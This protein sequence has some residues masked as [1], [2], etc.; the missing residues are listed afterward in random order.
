VSEPIVVTTP[1]EVRA[2]SRT[3]R[4]AGRRVALVPTMGALHDGHRS[5]I[6]SAASLADTVVVSIFVN[7]IQFDRADDFEAYPRL[8]VE[9]LALCA[10]AGAAIVYLPD[11]EHVYP[12]DFDTHVEPGALASVLEGE[13]RPG[14]F[15]GVAT[16]VTKLFGAVEPDLAVFG[17]KDFQQLA[18]IRRMTADLD[19][20]I[21][22]VAAPTQREPDGLAMSSRNRRLDPTARRAAVAIPDGL[23]A[24]QAAIA[25]G[26]HR[27]EALTD[28][29]RDHLRQAEAIDYIAI[30]DPDT[31][32]PFADLLADDGSPRPA[33]ALVAAWFGGVRLIDNRRLNG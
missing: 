32:A 17:E 5:L 29:V 23:A 2:L 1:A 20:G 8:P 13:H 21:E 25:D 9:D 31:L 26:E 11:V 3:E 19:L 18:V 30:V 33:V 7:P 10:S 6:T 27:V 4:R 15:T 14:H 16:V 28:I 24:A 22:I 12:P